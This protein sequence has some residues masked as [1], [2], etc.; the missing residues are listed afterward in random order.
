M[1]TLYPGND[2]ME[3]DPLF[4]SCESRSN[5]V[6][7]HRL[8]HGGI[9]VRS[10]LKVLCLFGVVLYT[11]KEKGLLGERLALTR[12]CLGKNIAP[13]DQGIAKLCE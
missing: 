9:A 12:T 10:G 5:N 13:G 1:E 3:K 4:T 11:D 7:V 6:Y 8:S 2:E